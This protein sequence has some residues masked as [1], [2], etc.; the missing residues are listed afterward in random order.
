[1]NDPFLFRLP[2]EIFTSKEE[3]AA[4]LF[5]SGNDRLSTIT[6]EEATNEIYRNF[7]EEL[8]D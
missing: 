6:L 8:G 7:V 2:D 5:I 3:A 4:A 1:M